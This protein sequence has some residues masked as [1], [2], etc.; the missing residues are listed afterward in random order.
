APAPL[1]RRRRP[2][3]TRAAGHRRRGA[4]DPGAALPGGRPVTDTGTG[5]VVRYRTG[6]VTADT[7]PAGPDRRHTEEAVTTTDDRDPS[8]LDTLS[9]AQAAPRSLGSGY[10]LVVPIGHGG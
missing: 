6:S 5:I 2:A 7:P 1:V 10:L 9:S 4:A 8:E 3:G